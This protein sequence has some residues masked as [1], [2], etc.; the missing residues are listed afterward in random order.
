MSMNLYEY[1]QHRQSI[2]ILKK[3]IFSVVKLV[4]TYDVLLKIDWI[5][6]FLQLRENIK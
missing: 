2:F 5:A 4:M 1:K 3:F 6:S